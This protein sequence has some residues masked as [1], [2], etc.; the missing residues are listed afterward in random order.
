MN[1]LSWRALP[2][3]CYWVASRADGR[4][5]A[6]YLTV[7]AMKKQWPR[8]LERFD[9]FRATTTYEKVVIG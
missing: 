8:G 7:D 6:V 1:R 4:P 2:A 3:E 5:I 9:V